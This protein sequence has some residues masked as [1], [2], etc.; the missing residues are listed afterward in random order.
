[1]VLTS[2][3]RCSP[4]ATQAPFLQHHVLTSWHFLA[5]NPTL[6]CVVWLLELLKLG[7]SLYRP[8]MPAELA[9]CYQILLSTQNESGSLGPKPSWLLCTLQGKSVKTHLFSFSF[10]ITAKYTH[11]QVLLGSEPKALFILS[12]DGGG[13]CL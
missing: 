9:P 8:C 13:A 2:L 4:V 3:T 5:G 1:M 11:L 6:P 7:A 12:P 10:S